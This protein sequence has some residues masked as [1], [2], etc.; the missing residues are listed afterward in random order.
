MKKFFCF[1]IM[2]IFS[3]GFFSCLETTPTEKHLN[4]LLKNIEFIFE[5]GD[6]FDSVTRN[7][8]FDKRMEDNEYIY[9]YSSSN[10]DVLSSDGVVNRVSLDTFVKITVSVSFNGRHKEKIFN[11]KVLALVNVYFIHYDLDG[12]I[13]PN[14]K[15][16]ITESDEEI[17]LLDPYK[18]HYTFI[19]WYLDLEKVTSIK[20][21]DLDSDITLTAK[22]ELIKYN[23]TYIV[24]VDGVTLPT[25][26]DF[27]YFDSFSLEPG[28][29]E[30]LQF[31]GWYLDIEYLTLITEVSERGEDL[32]LYGLFKR[33]YTITFDPGSGTISPSIE[34]VD[35]L[36]G[37]AIGILPISTLEFYDFL[38]WYYNDTLI[39]Q[40][41]I[42][43]FDTNIILLAK[44]CIIV[45]NI[46]YILDG[47]INNILNV[48]SFTYE[49]LLVLYEPTR[50]Y[51]EFDGFLVIESSLIVT[52]TILKDT[53]LNLGTN[54][55]SDLVIKALWSPITYS[56]NYELDGGT[57]SPYNPLT[58]D[59]TNIDFM[60]FEPIKVGFTFLGWSINQF[61][62]IFI[63]KIE[64]LESL[65]NIYL[66]ANWEINIYNI[67]YFPE[68]IINNISN[69]ATYTVLDNITLEDPSKD[70]YSFLGWYLEANFQN[71]IYIISNLT[72]DLEL[73]AKLVSLDSYIIT[74]DNDGGTTFQEPIY[75]SNGELI[76]SLFDSY[77]EGYYFLGW[78]YEE[79]EIEEGVIFD[80]EDNIILKA[81][82]LEISV[83]EEE[84]ENK[85]EVL[86]VSL[87][88]DTYLVWDT[89]PYADFYALSLDGVFILIS[90]DSYILL[91]SIDIYLD[92]KTRFTLVSKR[93][94]YKCSL[95][96]LIDLTF[97]PENTS[98]ISF[99]TDFENVTIASGYSD[100][101]EVVIND[102]DFI[103]HDSLIG[104]DANDKKNG[105]KSLRMR[106]AFIETTSSLDNITKISF[107]AGAYGTNN[108][109]TMIVE[110]RT[111]DSLIY[112][113]KA[114]F[115]LTSDL[116]YYS[117]DF[118]DS[119]LN[120]DIYIKIS[121]QSTNTNIRANIDDITF[122][123]LSLSFYS[124]FVKYPVTDTIDPGDGT[125]QG[126]YESING[127]TGIS[128]LLE[129]RNIISNMTKISYGDV[130]YAL[131]ETDKMVDDPTHVLGIYDHAPLPAY[132]DGG[133]TFNREH[134]WPNSRLGVKRVD[135]SNK[136]I[137]SDLHNLRA[138]LEN[139]NSS[140]GNRFYDNPVSGTNCQT[141]GSLAYYPGDS[142]KGDVSR[143]ILYMFVR[144]SELRLSNRELTNDSTTNYTLA[145]AEMSKIDVLLEWNLSD[146]VDEFEENRNET[147][148]EDY[149]HNRNPFIDHPELANKIFDYISPNESS[150]Y[151]NYQPSPRDLY[152]MILD[153]FKTIIFDKKI[154]F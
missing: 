6:S 36:A 24:E 132:W 79:I 67:S 31:L 10:E 42:Y 41:T 88:S 33:V 23:I 103:I 22:Y 5:E 35:V 138:V 71:Q 25:R 131:I 17:I 120:Q 139:T 53:T 113:T 7:V 100:N 45:Y 55:Y 64:D 111:S 52:G 72:G 20:F 154:Y 151:V 19:G 150:I 69:P 93:E 82:Y 56:I 54:I 142:D 153:L 16:R 50:L 89:D 123:S 66:Y 58:Y 108:P 92:G 12:G 94:G 44:Y 99:F 11:F 98:N 73:F 134:V 40:E 127:L 48:S 47:G 91:N 148:Y 146:T 137:A 68:D 61:F 21:S 26:I 135:N 43:N 85:L 105:L 84:Y 76:P 75:L 122:Y 57:N 147:I 97:I 121:Y 39:E 9:T 81:H 149:Q 106:K 65:D 116:V 141:V 102:V 32:V 8:T 30:T 104:T 95:E 3:V 126:Y 83:I 28:S 152:I 110:V 59:I 101:K 109:T 124:L 87:E 129:L 34:V 37:E 62:P 128:L 51:Y 49:T 96:V 117:L 125:Y 4:E 143:I 14:N 2:L 144:Y 18:E 130:R 15:D 118:G 74:F 145:G 29:H 90:Y 107:F 63:E 1:V 112:V 38:G 136:N 77:K 114:S 27:S 80:F 60:F 119:Y 78:Y 70:G 46:E 13:S 140:R 86:G 115:L 133:N